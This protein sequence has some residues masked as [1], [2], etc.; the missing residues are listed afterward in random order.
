MELLLALSL[1]TTLLMAIYLATDLHWKG[2]SAGR[3][4]V[5]RAQ[6]A[7]AIL[8]QMAVDI[9]SVIYR[10]STEDPSEEQ[11]LEEDQGELAEALGAGSET[12]GSSSD[13]ETIE[14][15]DPAEA[16]AAG[17]VGVVGTS[18]ELILHIS[19]PVADLAYAPL[20]AEDE[21]LG[22]TSDLRSVAWFMAGES[23]SALAEIVAAAAAETADA[24]TSEAFTGEGLARLEGDRLVM[25]LADEM[26]DLALMASQAR[27]LAPEVESVAFRY[28]DGESWWDSWDSTATGF[29]PRAIEITLQLRDS[30]NS[31][32]SF[33]NWGLPAGDETAQFRFVVD[34][35]L[36]EPYADG[37]TR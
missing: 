26:G 30:E 34:L 27:V 5:E 25:N 3:S 1:A 18:S 7:R 11:M 13:T 12:E 14:V 20:L 33:F 32:A 17:G 36:A 35:P 4:Q 22:P 8:R 15:T 9:R 23:G 19:R 24:T 6:L 2:S 28:F 16:L 29:L 21:L 37:S 31:E 10:P